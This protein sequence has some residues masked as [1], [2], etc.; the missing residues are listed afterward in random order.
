MYPAPCDRQVF[1]LFFKGVVDLVPVRRADPGIAFQKLPGMGSIPGLLVLI[2]DDL[3]ILIQRSGPV[4][5]H[6]A[7]CSGFPAVFVYEHRRFIR[8]DHMVAV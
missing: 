1:L 2:E 7:L 6:V 8:L 4:D 5:P 3:R